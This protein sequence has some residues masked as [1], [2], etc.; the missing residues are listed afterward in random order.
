[1]CGN[2]LL[3]AP[4]P[5]QKPAS[6]AP[7]SNAP[8]SSEPEANA[9]AVGPPEETASEQQHAESVDAT[10]TAGPEPLASS[11]TA[12]SSDASTS[13]SDSDARAPPEP[14]P[15]APRL[16]DRVYC[17]AAVPPEYVAS[18][19]RLVKVGGRAIM[20]VNDQVSRLCCLGLLPVAC[21]EPSE[22]ESV[23]IALTCLLC[24]ALL[25]S[26]LLSSSSCTATP[27][28]NNKASSH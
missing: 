21:C 12:T 8:L 28:P 23:G 24:A 20:P 1:M 5:S 4:V 10:A 6:S 16:Y 22:S 14:L 15:P 17:G 25:C 2:C 19:K 11:A 7:E 26:A 9:P 18:F 27:L 3:I 13:E